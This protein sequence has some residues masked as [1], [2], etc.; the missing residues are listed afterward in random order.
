MRQ[1]A[2]QTIGFISMSHPGDTLTV[3]QD[4]SSLVNNSNKKE[5]P[6]PQTIPFCEH[7]LSPDKPGPII[8]FPIIGLRKHAV[9]IIYDCSKFSTGWIE[10]AKIPRLHNSQVFLF[11]SIHGEPKRLLRLLPTAEQWTIQ[12]Y[13]D[14]FKE[15]SYKEP[16]KIL[17]NEFYFVHEIKHGYAQIS[18]WPGG[19]QIG[20]IPIYSPDGELQI[21]LVLHEKGIHPY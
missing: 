2:M 18:Q 15:M 3:F 20:W 5:I 9:E 7:G 11:D 8:D 14:P 12:V 17:K 1:V 19:E 16:M 10:L 21:W 6:I 13:K 4:Y